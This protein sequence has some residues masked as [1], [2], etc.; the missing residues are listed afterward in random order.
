[1]NV[2]APNSTFQIDDEFFG[3]ERAVIARCLGEPGLIALAASRLSPNDFQH[4]F[5]A[6]CFKTLVDVH[7]EGR[8]P[9]LETLIRF[10]GDDEV[11]GGLTARNFL[12]RLLRS[13]FIGQFLPIEDAIGVI[14]D[15]ARRNQIARIGGDLVRSATSPE[16]VLKTASDAALELDDLI[17]S[18]R[19]GDR[20][21]FDGNGIA[22]A[23][24]E[25]LDATD[26]SNPT[27]GLTD[28]DDALGGWPKGEMSVVAARPGMGKS[29]FATSSRESWPRLSVLQPRNDGEADQRSHAGRHRLHAR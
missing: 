29:A 17:A 23:A 9:S 11:E 15:T 5:L 13:S 25:H 8:K 14:R 16:S 22:A 7:D 1:V 21:T 10:F 24:F 2:F 18:C 12:T 28:L 6:K 27:T 19:Q 3:A 4:E 20:Q 26:L